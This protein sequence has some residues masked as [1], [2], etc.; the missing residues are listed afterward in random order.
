MVDVLFPRRNSVSPRVWQ[1]FVWSLGF[2][3]VLG[4]TAPALARQTSKKQA[5]AKASPADADSADGDQ[6]KPKAKAAAD[7]SA[8]DPGTPPATADESALTRKFS[9]NEIFRDPKAE[10][11]LDVSAFK[12]VVKP[13]ITNAERLQLNAI[14]GGADQN[15]DKALIERVVDAMAAKLTDHTNIQAIIDA[16]AK[17]NP[18][19]PA[20]HAIQ[21]ATTTLLDPLFGAKSANNQNFLTFYNRTLVQKLVPLLKNHLIPRVQAMIILGQSGSKEMLPV[22]EA[23]IK[24]E[25]QTMWVKLW[26]IEGIIN[27]VESGGRLNGTE[28]V[29]AAKVVADFLVNEENIPWPAQLR[30]LEAL[31]ALRAGFEPNKPRDAAMASA[32]MRYLSDTEAKPEVRSEAARA[33]GSM[34]ISSAVPKYNYALI[35]HSI[36]ELAADLATEIEALLPD[37]PVSATAKTARA[38][39]EKLST[40]T[41]GR[42]TAERA[43]K[44]IT[45][46]KTLGA[47]SAP[48]QKRSINPAKAK[49]LTALMVGPVYQAL[50]G[51][52][53]KSDSGLINANAGESAAFVQKVFELVKP[54]AKS[55]V[56]NLY[57]GA[58]QRDDNKKTLKAQV[59]ALREFLDQNEPADHHLVQGGIEFPVEKIDEPKEAPAPAPKKSG[60][61]RPQP[62]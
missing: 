55:T 25:K 37:S 10:E 16:N 48:P 8:A 35:A 51:V 53:S 38:P 34:P 18:N 43:A 61:R 13:A 9:P 3:V 15:L 62:R 23:Q 46:P 54:V 19:S 52:P 58:R 57:S 20:A 12:A 17:I 7:A 33:L 42:S 56:D 26:A 41:K 47:P 60:G 40:P 45:I 49:Y 59:A 1:G 28:Q 29:N 27:L 36:G 4:S 32:A 14:A 44:G 39:D 6:E 11:M 24:D 30:A 5:P 50:S 21:E 2:A 22:Y 31:S